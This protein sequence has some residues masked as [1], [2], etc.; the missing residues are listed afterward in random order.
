M[1]VLGPNGRPLNNGQGRRVSGKV[2]VRIMIEE[3]GEAIGGPRLREFERKVRAEVEKIPA[4][5]RTSNDWIGAMAEVIA[6][7]QDTKADEGF[8]RGI[9]RIR[10]AAE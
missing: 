6:R 3:I 8:K 1:T 4:V 9:R 5:A 10:K 2:A 7:D